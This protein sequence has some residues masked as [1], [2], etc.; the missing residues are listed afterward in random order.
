MYGSRIAQKL[1]PARAQKMS[2]RARSG[3]YPHGLI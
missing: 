1:I 3:M 2:S